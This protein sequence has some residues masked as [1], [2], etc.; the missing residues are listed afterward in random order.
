MPGGYRKWIGARRERYSPADS[1][2]AGLYLFM[3]SLASSRATVP[4][5]AD[6]NWGGAPAASIFIAVAA[7]SKSPVAQDIRATSEGMT[8]WSGFLLMLV[9]KISNACACW[10]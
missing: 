4:W 9:L 3:S 1:S 8:Q 6:L 5:N 2:T 10:P 7:L